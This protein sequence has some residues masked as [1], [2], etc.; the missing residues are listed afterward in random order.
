MATLDTMIVR[1]LATEI[2]AG[3][4]EHPRTITPIDAAAGGKVARRVAEQGFAKVYLRPRE[5][6]HVRLALD[7]RAFAM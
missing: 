1:R 3:L 6:R 7:R 2:R 4:F 5:R